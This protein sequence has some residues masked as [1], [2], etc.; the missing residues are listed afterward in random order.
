[1]KQLLAI[2]LIALL[3][4]CVTQQRCLEKYPPQVKDSVVYKGRLEKFTDTLRL[5]GEQVQIRDTIPCP[6]ANISKEVKRGNVTAKLTIK[7]GVV[8]VDCKTDSLQKV[9]DHYKLL[10]EKE[11]YNTKTIAVP[12]TRK[13]DIVVRWIAAIEALFIII[14]LIAGKIFRW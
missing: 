1:M 2:L 7:K 6:E 3:T 14:N 5:P 9:I 12:T 10:Y 11:L 4:S 13:I 8:T